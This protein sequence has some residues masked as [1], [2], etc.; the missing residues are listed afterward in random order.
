M[1]KGRRV[2]LA[3]SLAVAGALALSGCGGGGGGGSA[4]TTVDGKVYDGPVWGAKVCAYDVSNKELGC[5]ETG[6]DGSYTLEVTGTVAYLKAE[7]Q[8]DTVDLGF[9]KT[10]NTTDDTAFSD[11]LVADYEDSTN[12]T[13]LTYLRHLGL[14]TDDISKD[15]S[16][17]AMLDMQ[18]VVSAVEMLKNL[19]LTSEEAYKTV[20]ESIGAPAPRALGSIVITKAAIEKAAPTKATT[21]PESV[22][23]KVTSAVSNIATVVKNII[24]QVQQ[25]T[26]ITETR[27]RTRAQH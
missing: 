20:K 6:K 11:I 21:I 17:L 10:F 26:S 4:T 25:G 12:I 1:F 15:V 8:S 5:T 16:D 18:V 23:K 7:P 22:V 2:S 14:K 9:D 3:A 13:P 19:G 24:K 27:P